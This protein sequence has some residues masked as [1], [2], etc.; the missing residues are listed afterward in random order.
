MKKIVLFIAFCVNIFLNSSNAMAQCLQLV[1]C[2]TDTMG[3]VHGTSQPTHP[4]HY[5]NDTFVICNSHGGENNYLYNSFPT[6][7]YGTASAFSMSF[8]FRIDSNHSCSDGLTFWFFTS[9]LY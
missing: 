2:P 9:S 4:G 8:D 1:H 5:N 6:T 7:L 3:W